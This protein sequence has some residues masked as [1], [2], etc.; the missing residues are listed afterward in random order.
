[1]TYNNMIDRAAAS[2]S[3]PPVN[4]ASL[5]PSKDELQLP[6]SARSTLSNR[7]WLTDDKW[8]DEDDEMEAAAA[9]GFMPKAAGGNVAPPVV[10]SGDHFV[11]GNPSSALHQQVLFAQRITVCT[12]VQDCCKGRSN[13]YRKWHFLGSC[14]P[15]TP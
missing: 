12:V 11:S 3:V 10:M 13:K 4:L 9:A 14:R 2:A 15:E 5:A 6:E 7:S 8:S 1:M